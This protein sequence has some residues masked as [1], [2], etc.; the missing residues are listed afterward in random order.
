MQHKVYDE[1][2][3]LRDGLMISARNGA[4]VEFWKFPP[5][6]RMRI[7]HREEPK[8][9]PRVIPDCSDHPMHP[10]LDIGDPLEY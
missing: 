6:I 3:E 4:R 1:L 7:L 2:W 5:E 10:E 9:Y 8:R